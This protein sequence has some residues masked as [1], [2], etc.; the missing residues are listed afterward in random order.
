[1][2]SPVLHI[3]DSYFFE[4]PKFLWSRN[5]R[6]LD[7]VPA[8]LREAHP[9]ASLEEFNYELSGKI[10]IPQPL[11]TQ[12][13]LYEMESGFGIS[14]FMV[15][16]LLVSA[17]LVLAFSWL[18]K[19]RRESLVPA[20]R[21]ENLMESMVM[22]V[23]D[24]IARPS[25]GEHDADKFV[26]YLLTC[27]FFVLTANL[28]GM[29][30]GIGTITSAIEITAVLA[31]FTFVVGLVAGIQHF[32]PVGYI[33]N[34]VPDIDLPAILSPLK[35]LIFVIEIF[36]LVIKHCVL[37]VRLFGNMVAGHMVLASILGSIVAV[38]GTGYWYTGAFFGVLGA[39]ALSVL[40]I[41]VS[42]I[43]AY[44]FTMLSA[45]FIGMSVHKH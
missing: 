5:Y 28:M 39:V 26:P 1:M 45:L 9:E 44:V 6:T 42:F 41:L 12:R 11:G 16:L 35:L 43:Q 38:A 15:V 3:K 17:G 18:A 27:F 29:V 20:T 31:G 13:N 4:V 33:M 10:L 22:Y 30:P 32:G 24:E 25:I 23:R 36:G 21:R 14:R 19:R 37:A 8:F 2:A 7:D 34:F 40:E